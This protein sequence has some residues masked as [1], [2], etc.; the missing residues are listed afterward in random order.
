MLILEHLRN[1]HSLMQEDAR[2]AMRHMSFLDLS[3]GG[4][5]RARATD[6]Y[7]GVPHPVKKWSEEANYLGLHAVQ[8]QRRGKAT[9]EEMLHAEHDA[10]QAHTY[11]AGV[12]KDHPHLVALHKKGASL[13][14]TRKADL[15]R[16]HGIS[17]DEAAKP[18]EEEPEE[19]DPEDQ[20]EPR[21]P[22]KPDSSAGFP[23]G[24][25]RTEAKKQKP[26]P[27][28]DHIKGYFAAA[29]AANEYS[30]K[31]QQPSATYDTHKLAANRH[32]IAAG[33]ALVIGRSDLHKQH[34]KQFEFH[35]GEMAK[36]KGPQAAA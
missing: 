27:E 9:P 32:F 16:K 15:T 30:A 1:I 21:P 12:A 26:A 6:L 14:A 20:P 25:A 29:D 4:S 5:V 28:D 36:L 35:R 8:L 13:H 24:E 31:T 10:E 2:S 7:A 19:E 3:E 22:K 33:H 11:A 23:R 34:M 17:I 18:E